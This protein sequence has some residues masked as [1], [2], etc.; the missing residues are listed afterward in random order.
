MKQTFVLIA[1]AIIGFSTPVLAQS[2]DNE[3]EITVTNAEGK[4]EIIDLPEAM[5]NEYDSLLSVYNNRT[6]LNINTDCNMPD[7]NPVY[8]KEVYKERLARI[9][10]VIEL[11]YNDVVQ[12]FIDRYSGRLR[13][14]VS[15]MLG[16]QNFYMPTF[17]E[18]LESYGLPLELKYLPVIESALNPNAV[19]HVGATGLWQ[20]M[21]TTG[22]QYG[23][24]I[25][26]LVDERRDPVRASYAAAH[27]LRDLYKIFG[28]WNL[29]IAAYNC[30]PENIN[31][32]IHRSN[33]A[34]DY[35]QIYPYLP[36][37]TRGYVPAFIAANYI[38]NYY[39][40]HNICPM[41]AN[42]PGKTDTV[43]V[44]RDVH[45][46]QV[47]QVLGMEIDQIKQ[48]NPQYRRNI[49]N[50]STR[51]MALRLPATLVGKF[52]D[53]ED[54]IYAYRPDVLLAKRT[55]VE[56]NDDVPSY[57][58]RSSSSSR[59]K[60]SSSRKSRS[61]GKKG[62]KNKGGRNVTIRQGDTLSDIAKRNGTTVRKLKKLNKI[63]GSS[64]R[65]GKKLRIK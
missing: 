2:D 35:W 45:F 64:I 43:V 34:T 55:E 25:N 9:P 36:K 32:A 4:K 24:E 20:F 1:A 13:R 37:E 61:K 59:S 60:S 14:S 16:A 53:N 28:D 58:R 41:Q 44:S 50:G 56:V 22:K 27:Y 33:G 40:D 30:G 19:S 31:K 5:T 6:Y 10:S 57:S 18:A 39:C 29:V 52:I 12:K 49:V 3:T 8:S 51:P 46:E 48:L 38:M 65:A 17:E 47:A 63:S 15:I 62:K 7:V 11:P 21:L 54:S 23:L 26:S 42:L